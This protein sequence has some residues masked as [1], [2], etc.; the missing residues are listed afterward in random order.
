MRYLK[1]ADPFH[2]SGTIDLPKAEGIAA[3]WHFIKGL[4]GNTHP[5]AVLPFGKYSVCP[6][7]GG[8][9][10]GY[11]INQLQVSG[12]RLSER[13]GMHRTDAFRFRND[14]RRRTD[15]PDGRIRIQ[16]E[17]ALPGSRAFLYGSVNQQDTPVEI[18]D[19][20]MRRT[21]RFLTVQ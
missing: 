2:G 20:N 8:Y 6:Y 19:L 16:T 21:V 10:S 11:G 7:T 9:S 15:Y 3:S 4:C 18:G 1:Y 13:H 5:G 12:F 14:E 17:K